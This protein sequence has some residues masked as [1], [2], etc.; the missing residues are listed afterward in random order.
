VA[1]TQ[2]NAGPDVNCGVHNHHDNIFQ[3]IHI[4]LSAGTEDGGMSRVKNK[5]AD[6]P[7]SKISD[8][9]DTKFDHVPLPEFYEHGGLWYQDSYNEAVRE[10]NN[11]VSYPWHKW[12]AGSGENVDV[13]LALEFNPD[14]ETA[15]TSAHHARDKRRQ[16]PVRGAQ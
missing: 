13:W 16:I 7:P 9:D 1:L 2:V 3:E 6:T 14:L 12:Q 10:V 15:G 11:V 8:L 4:C 5:Y